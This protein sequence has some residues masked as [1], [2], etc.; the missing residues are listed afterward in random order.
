MPAKRPLLAVLTAVCTLVSYLSVAPAQAAPPDEVL[1]TVADHLTSFSPPDGDDMND[2]ERELKNLYDEAHVAF[3]AGRYVDAGN[4]FDAG[5]KRSGITAFL[6]NSAVAWERAGELERAAERYAEYIVKVPDADD[7]EEMEERL[8]A[9]RDAITNKTEAQVEEMGTK[10]VAIITSTPSRAEIRIDSPD[11]EVFATTPFRGTLP[12]GEHVVYV[13]AKGYK[14]SYQS[15]PDNAG[16][17]L[18]GR[19][20]LSEE[21]F[22]G[23]LEIGSPVAGAAVYLDRVEDLEGN[24]V[25]DANADASVGKTPFANQVTPGKY[26]VRIEA[27]GYRPYRTT[28]T[29]EQGKVKTL[30]VELELIEGAL[31]NLR[32]ADTETLGA[33]AFLSRQSKEPLCTLPC[34]VEI[35]TGKHVVVVRKDK[36]KTLEFDIDVAQADLVEVDVVMEPATKRYPAIVTGALMAGTLGTGIFFGLQSRRLKNEIED[37]LANFEQIDTDDERAQIGKRNAIVA[38]ALFGATAVLGALT[39]FYAV[40]QTGEPSRGEKQQRNL[41]SKRPGRRKPPG[42]RPRAIFAPAVGGGTYGIAGEVKF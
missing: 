9:L 41:A 27:A 32:A 14:T 20:A 25:D 36:K 29:V 17:V 26:D 40:R 42:S 34:E 10:G 21:Y 2:E 6:F 16:K 15:F 1:A 37:D 30:K 13:S 22:L 24:V 4:Q 39:I 19:Y 23:Q 11:A 12:A 5:Y 33:Q 3:L 35:P 18:V 31:L 8:A 38:D 7:R 28:I